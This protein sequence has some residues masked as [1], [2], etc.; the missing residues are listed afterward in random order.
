MPSYFH[1]EFSASFPTTQ[2]SS[3][4]QSTRTSSSPGTR[5]PSSTPASSVTTLVQPQKP[6]K[7]YEQAFGNLS[8]SYGF[9]GPVPCVPPKTSE[10]MSFT[11]KCKSTLWVS[12]FVRK[13][14]NEIVF[15]KNRK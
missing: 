12:P 10:K 1:T 15:S 2:S 14:D 5:A 9:A 6:A 7:D 4:K 13:A 8:S 11:A 3:K